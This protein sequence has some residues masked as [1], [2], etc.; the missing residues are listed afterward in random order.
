MRFIVESTAIAVFG[1]LWLAIVCVLRL[2]KGKSYQYLILFSVFYVYL[3]KVID[4]TLIQFQALL[5]LRHFQPNLM[6]NGLSESQ[7]VNPIPLLSL[8]S[9]QLKTSLLN[10]LLMMPFGFGL[11]FLS[12]VRMKQVVVLGAIFSVSIELLQFMTGWIGGITFRVADINDV[13]FNTIGAAAGYSLFT[14]FR[15]L[16]HY[17]PFHVQREA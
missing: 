5:L 4:Y 2:K 17:L 13:I 16:S 7:S 9:G 10:I 11:P 3:F 8:T 14:G 15:R 6:L 1:V 12:R